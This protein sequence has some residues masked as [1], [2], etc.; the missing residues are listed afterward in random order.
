[1][2]KP[3]L[4]ETK[5][6][7]NSD[8]SKCDCWNCYLY[9]LRWLCPGLVFYNLTLAIFIY[10]IFGF[11]L[12]RETWGWFIQL[13]LSN[14]SIYSKLF[15][16]MLILVRDITW[17]NPYID[18]YIWLDTHANTP[19]L[20]TGLV[21]ARSCWSQVLLKPS[22]VESRSCWN[23]VMLKAGLGLGHLYN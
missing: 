11:P 13:Y 6:C 12:V 16:I 3:G 5:Y 9:P 8:C 21:E 1:M 7:W 17:P 10:I 22:H 23:Q 18:T 4:V 2:L 14:F 20:V 15:V 19:C